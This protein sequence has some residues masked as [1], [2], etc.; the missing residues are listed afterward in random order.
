M[1]ISPLKAKPEGEGGGWGRRVN[2]GM[3]VLVH[4]TMLTIAT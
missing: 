4:C 3:Y 2:V 1:N